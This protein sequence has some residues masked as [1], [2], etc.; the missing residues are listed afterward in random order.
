MPNYQRRIKKL[1]TKKEKATARDLGGSVTPGS[2]NVD[3]VFM[4]EDVHSKHF[5]LQ[6]KFTEKK[7][8]SIK[9]KD[10]SLCEDRALRQC[11]M[12]AHRIEFT[13][14]G[15]DVAVIRWQ[16]FLQ[17]LMDAGYDE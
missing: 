2:G 7:S 10:F 16:D 14:T 6:H 12:P 8:Y 15:E 11:K 4:K 5:V 1:S 17:L 3:N 13:A 9:A